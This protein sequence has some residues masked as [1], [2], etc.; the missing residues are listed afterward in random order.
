MKMI[1]YEVISG[2]KR[3]NTNQER[4]GYDRE[5]G[6]KDL[7]G[8]ATKSLVTVSLKLNSIYTHMSHKQTKIYKDLHL[9]YYSDLCTELLINLCSLATQISKIY[10]SA[11]RYTQ[12]HSMQTNKHKET[13]EDID[14]QRQTDRHICIR[15][16]YAKYTKD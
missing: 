16:L 11:V 13:C 5:Q 1:Y 8:R 10:I 12:W 3:E 4:I 7:S 15:Y 9:L 14:M 2:N 6:D